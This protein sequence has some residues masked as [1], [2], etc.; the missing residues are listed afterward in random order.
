MLRF[1]KQWT[2]PVAILTGILT[3]LIYAHCPIFDATRPYAAP[4]VSVVQPSL[5]FLM[6]FLTFCKIELRSLRLR[7][8][9]LWLLL[10]QSLSFAAMCL[11]IHFF[12]AMPGRVVME[13][14]LLCMICPTATAAAVVTQKLKGNA[15]DVT[16][17]TILINLAVAVLVPLFV[18]FIHPSAGSGF[19]PL[20]LMILRK[21]FPLLILP[22]IAARLLRHLLPG[23]HRRIVS[24]PNLAFYLWAVALSI[25]ISVSV[26]SLVHSSCPVVELWG[27]G[28]V[29]LACCI[30]QFAFGRYVGTHTGE[31]VSTCQSLGQKNTVFAIWMGYTFLNPVVSLAGG[32][33]SIWHNLYNTWQMRRAERG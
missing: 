10:V 6:L 17:Y 14:A 7:L 1:L 28:L 33:Y 9:H 3:Y 20:F 30:F 26:R 2:L 32:F 8:A 27:I 11:I 12:P 18:P 5:L 15:T 16:A 29:S 19:G 22:L 25:A 31:A 21:V 23:L 13:S 4:V 24:F